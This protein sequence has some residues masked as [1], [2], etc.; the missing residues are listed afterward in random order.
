MGV[1]KHRYSAQVGELS[2]AI[3]LRTQLRFL[4]NHTEWA[5]PEKWSDE[6]GKQI[7][8]QLVER[9]QALFPEAEEMTHKKQLNEVASVYYGLMAYEHR[10]AWYRLFALQV[11]RGIVWIEFGATNHLVFTLCLLAGGDAFA[12]VDDLRQCVERYERQYPFAFE[13][14][15]GY[16]VAQGDFVGTGYFIRTWMSVPA[17]TWMHHLVQLESAA[18]VKESVVTFD[19]PEGEAYPPGGVITIT[20]GTAW[21]RPAVEL[22]A[23]HIEMVS[24]AAQEEMRARKCYVADYS[25]LFWDR[26]KRAQGLLKCVELLTEEEAL[27]I[28]AT[29]AFALGA[30]VVRRAAKTK[31]PKNIATLFFELRGAFVVQALESQMSEEEQHQ[32]TKQIP[33]G[34]VRNG[35]AYDYCRVVLLRRC[36]T[37]GMRKE[38]EER[39]KVWV[40][41]D[42]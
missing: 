4:R 25:F 17:L 33:R 26:I 11:E 7:V 38:F 39:A 10:P 41:N 29:L 23:R 13:M 35:L 20:N 2:D 6:E 15:W 32:L 14:P 18:K 27:E 36:F 8:A 37:I 24:I 12:A 30:G 34:V 42:E 40:S 19:G 21:D 9:V 1:F 28:L 31:R 3:V 22:T 5:F 16:L